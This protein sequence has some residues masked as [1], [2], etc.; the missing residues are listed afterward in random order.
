MNHFLSLD[1]LG[2]RSSHNILLSISHPLSFSVTHHGGPRTRARDNGLPMEVHS[3]PTSQH[4]L[5]RS[6]PH[7]GHLDQ[8]P[9]AQDQDLVLQ[10]FRD[11]MLQYALPPH[12]PSHLTPQSG[13]N[14]LHR[15]RP[16][17]QQNRTTSTL[18]NPSS[19]HPDPA[20]LLRSNNLHDPRTHHPLRR[21][22]PPVNNQPPHRNTRLR[23]GRSRI[24]Q[25]P[26]SQ[27][28]PLGS[29]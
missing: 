11:R 27:F 2:T 10:L 5:R 13:S 3:Q 6:I 28:R 18:P 7:R 26:G 25:R 4:R 16:V 1:A 9:N 8:F 14:R 22:R 19:L 15:T 24:F 17:R 20:R 12:S 29:P 21:R 23:L